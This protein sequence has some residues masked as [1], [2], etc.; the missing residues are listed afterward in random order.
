MLDRF[1]N[2]CVEKL[3]GHSNFD[4]SIF[5]LRGVN[6]LWEM[7]GSLGGYAGMVNGVVGL[8]K[9]EV[10]DYSVCSIYDPTARVVFFFSQRSDLFY[11]ELGS[12]RVSFCEM[13]QVPDVPSSRSRNRAS[14][15]WVGIKKTSWPMKKTSQSTHLIR[16]A[17]DMRCPLR[18]LGFSDQL[19]IRP[20]SKVQWKLLP[21][22]NSSILRRDWL[23]R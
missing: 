11:S 2:F 9:L 21:M 1:L 5:R 14:H 12:L 13:Y 7:S 22:A 23:K 8:N 10:L 18:I 19:P 6:R 4:V 17:N 3:D 16:I 20:L 15:E